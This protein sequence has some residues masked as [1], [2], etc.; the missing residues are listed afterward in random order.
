MSCGMAHERNVTGAGY[1]RY[2][3]E[4]EVTSSSFGTRPLLKLRPELL[5]LL[6]PLRE[7]RIRELL[8]FWEAVKHFRYML[9]ARRKQ[10]H[11]RLPLE[12]GQMTTAD[13]R[14]AVSRRC[15][16]IG[17]ADSNSEALAATP[18]ADARKPCRLEVSRPP[19]LRGPADT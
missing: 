1:H 5:R 4:V 9:E 15:A 18:S 12:T 10:H 16:Y 11:V 3:A 2:D 14:H 17:S 7:H 6:S 8:V 13:L 19:T